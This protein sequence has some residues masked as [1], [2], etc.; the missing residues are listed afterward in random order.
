MLNKHANHISAVINFEVIIYYISLHTLPILFS[1]LSNLSTLFVLSF[2]IA[3]SSHSIM[4][5]ISLHCLSILLS[6][7][8][9]LSTLSLSLFPSHLTQLCYYLYPLSLY[10]LLISLNFVYIC[11]YSL[12]LSSGHPIYLRVSTIFSKIFLYLLLISLIFPLFLYPLLI[13]LNDVS[14]LSPPSLSILFLSHLY[15]RCL[16]ISLH[17][18][19]YLLPVS[20][21]SM[22]SYYL[23]LLSLSIL[24]G[25]LS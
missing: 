25:P 5:T 16:A 14:Y 22:I 9:N 24:H 10:P 8:S 11:L 20:S 7:F 19:F 2:F 15:Q 6:S 17:P 21:L 18:F 1:S 12:S 4:L 3:F 13:T 23:S